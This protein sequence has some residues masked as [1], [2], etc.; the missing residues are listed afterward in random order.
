MPCRESLDTPKKV[1]VVR[2]KLQVDLDGERAKLEGKL[3][4]LGGTRK[5]DKLG[6]KLWGG[7][8]GK[9]EQLGEYDI[10][11]AGTSGGS[12]LKAKA[13]QACS[14]SQCCSLMGSQS[15]ALEIAQ[16]C[17]RQSIVDAGSVK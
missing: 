15:C 8:T 2:D 12:G 1:T 7:W 10:H 16:T 6:G 9:L 14:Q 13:H 3:D 11:Q 4:K 5:L 17:E